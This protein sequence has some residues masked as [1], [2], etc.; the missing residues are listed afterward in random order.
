[1]ILARHTPTETDFGFT[2]AYSALTLSKTPHTYETSVWFI[3][4]QDG[5]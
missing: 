3:Q 1:M 4:H 5:K 2:L